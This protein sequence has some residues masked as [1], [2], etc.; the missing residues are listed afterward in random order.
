MS[1]ETVIVADNKFQAHPESYDL[2]VF[3]ETDDAPG[4]FELLKTGQAIPWLVSPA[5][6][7]F[8]F[9]II[10]A[11]AVADIGVSRGNS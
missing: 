5:G 8:D 11:S 2:R 10:K 4:F 7:G 6:R 9:W 1:Q 3:V